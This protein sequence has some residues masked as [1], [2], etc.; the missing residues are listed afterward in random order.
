M[1]LVLP[2]FFP[3]QHED[4]HLAFKFLES[5]L[6]NRPIGDSS[7]FYYCKQKLERDGSIIW[8]SV[9]TGVLNHF[10]L[11]LEATPLDKLGLIGKTSEY[12]VN[13]S[14][15]KIIYDREHPLSGAWF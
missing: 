10:V 4:E 14:C 2:C 15:N 8:V 13:I 11:E 5:A 7:R 3:S 6:Q 9:D 1:Y 12:L